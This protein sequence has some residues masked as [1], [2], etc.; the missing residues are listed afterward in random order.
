MDEVEGYTILNGLGT[1]R[2]SRVYEVLDSLVAKYF[3]LSFHDKGRHEEEILK[4]L[5]NHNIPNIPRCH[6]LV[7]RPNYSALIVSPVGIPIIFASQNNLITSNMILKLLDV[8]EFVHN[9]NIVHRDV[10]PENIFLSKN[11]HTEIILND[12]GSA[13]R[14]DALE[15]GECDYEGTPLYGEQ[16]RDGIKQVPTKKLDLRCLVKTVFTI[17]QQKYPR[18]KK[19]WGEIEAYWVNVANTYPQFL[20][21]LNCAENEGYAELR[22]IFQEMWY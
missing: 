19:T 14:L 8:L 16:C 9:L 21:V 10:K 11:D 22:R 15:N 2:F 12:W 20:N 6:D 3:Q 13:V 18:L 7:V 1:G 17:K 4:L 5:R